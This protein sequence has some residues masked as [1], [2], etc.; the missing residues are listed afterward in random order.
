MSNKIECPKCSSKNAY[1]VRKGYDVVLRCTCGMHMVMQTELEQITIEHTEIDVKLP[2]EGTNL[3][4]T[5]NVLASMVTATSGEVQ[6]ALKDQ[7]ATFDMSDTS[8]YLTI[9]KSKGLVFRVTV[10]RSVAGG[11]TWELTD[12]AR[13]L[14]GII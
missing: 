4:K 8:T 1:L 11:S 2:K 13:D 5:L 10:R 12:S 7:G 3:R 14:L 6:Q 9:L